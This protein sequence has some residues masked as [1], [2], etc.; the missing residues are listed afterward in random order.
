MGNG[1]A[2][3]GGV[4]NTV[5]RNRVWDHDKTGIGLIPF[6]EETPNDDIP[7][8]DEWDRPCCRHRRRPGEHRAARRPPVGLA[9]QRRQRQRAVRQPHRRHRRR[10]RPAPI[11]RHWATASPATTS[12]CRRRPTSRRSRRARATGSG[13]WTVDALDVA[14]WLSEERPPSV[15]YEDADLPELRPQENMPDAA[16]APAEPATD[17]PTRRRPRRHRVPAA[18]QD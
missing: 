11:R 18:P 2:I 15:D 9:G 12:R 1:I 6:L 3:A 8:P 5:E 16:T 4:G 7:S 17:M 13:D 14:S 10:R